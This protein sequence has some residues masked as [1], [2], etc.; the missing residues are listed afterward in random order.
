MKRSLISGVVLIFFLS[1][2][3]YFQSQDERTAPEL[4]SEGMDAYKKEKFKKSI[5]AFEKLKNWYPFSKFAILAE[6]KKADAHYQL[7]EYEEA[8]FAYEEFENLHPRNEAIPYVIYQIG[9]SYFDQIDTMD[10]DQ[11]TAKKAIETFVRL[12]KQFP[13]D[14][15]S[16]KAQI[17][18][19]K[20]QKSLAQ[21]DLY[22]GIFYFRGK[23]YSAA[24]SRFKLILNNYPDVGVHQEALRYIAKS[25]ALMAEK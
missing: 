22:V 17:H 21:H 5:E 6:L 1:G 23:H 14:A 20:C 3:S 2:C 7:K 10:R 4:A 18:I 19:K 24:I 16:K 11:E 15:Y 9:R 8:I 25:E 12:K 13:K